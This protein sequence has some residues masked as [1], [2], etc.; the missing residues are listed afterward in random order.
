[1]TEEVIDRLARI[2][3]KLDTALGVSK[4]HESRIRGTEQ[5]IW[6]GAGAFSIMTALLGSILY[7]M[8]H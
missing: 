1:M 8:L 5:K 2:E 7:K 3:E 6:G 4:D